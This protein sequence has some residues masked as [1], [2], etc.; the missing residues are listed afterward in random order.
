MA[1]YFDKD[2]SFLGAPGNTKENSYKSFNSSNYRMV[3]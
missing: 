2:K 3:N 1:Q